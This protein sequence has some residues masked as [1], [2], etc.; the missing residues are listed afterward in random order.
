MLFTFY[1]PH[2]SH[3]LMILTKLWSRIHLAFNLVDKDPSEASATV[4]LQEHFKD[5]STNPVL[6][7]A[8]LFA[9]LL[10]DL[11]H[12]VDVN[13]TPVGKKHPLG[14][15]CHKRCSK[16]QISMDRGWQVFMDPK[17]Q[18]LRSCIVNSTAE[19]ES[20]RSNVYALVNAD[21]PEMLRNSVSAVIMEDVMQASVWGHTMQHWHVYLKVSNDAKLSSVVIAALHSNRLPFVSVVEQEALF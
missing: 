3:V 19:L 8:S 7:F 12:P 5:L 4:Q 20:F 14:Q 9:A 16:S 18:I 17:F 6:H 13:G 10:H 11:D 1:V 2:F 21:Q 15:G